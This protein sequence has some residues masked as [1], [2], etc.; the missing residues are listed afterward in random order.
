VVHLFAELQVEFRAPSL[1]A[2]TRMADGHQAMAEMLASMPPGACA[3]RRQ[4]AGAGEEPG[5]CKDKIRALEKQLRKVT[6]VQDALTDTVQ[7]QE[8]TIAAQAKI[9]AGRRAVQTEDA[10]LP[11]DLSQVATA[12]YTG[13]DGVPRTCAADPCSME[14]PLCL[15]GGQCTSAPAPPPP[16]GGG[17]RRLQDGSTP[18]AFTCSC[19]RGWSGERCEGEDKARPGGNI[20]GGG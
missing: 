11:D 4:M 16:S 15:N 9:I 10:T 13:H 20:F 3:D 14:P 6:A 18:P 8:A 17:H 2:A 1:E 19:E 7:K 12:V 5:P